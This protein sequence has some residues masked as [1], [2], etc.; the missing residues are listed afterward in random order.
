MRPFSLGVDS[1]GNFSLAYRPRVSHPDRTEQEG[2][3]EDLED[4]LPRK[5]S[6]EPPVTLAR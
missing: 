4:K 1:N 3:V 5:L 2:D 6:G